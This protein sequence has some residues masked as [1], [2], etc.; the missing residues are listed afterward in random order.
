M[1]YPPSPSLFFFFFFFL[2]HFLSLSL[3]PCL[4]LSPSFSLVDNE[5]Q[6][7]E[8][9][10]ERANH[11]VAT[12]STLREHGNNMLGSTVVDARAHGGEHPHQKFDAI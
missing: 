5:C 6:K 10:S 1:L 9:T 4:C 7:I 3:S 11:D 2:S 12:V 8:A